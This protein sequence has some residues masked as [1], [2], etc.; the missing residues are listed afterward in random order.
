M[1]V[2][3]IYG[4][5]GLGREVMELAQIINR[6]CK[7]WEDF[8]FIDD[9]DVPDIVNNY[10]VYKYDVAKEK[11]RNS[12]EIVVGIGE[13]VTR[14]KL[15]ERIKSDNIF[16][17]SLIHPDVHVPTTTQIGAGVVIQYGCF[18]SCDVV[19]EDYVYIQPQCNIGHDDV[20]KKG[21]M[22]AS[23]FHS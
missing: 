7:K 8:I 10:K 2:L 15:F 5:S 9:G 16:T 20:L 4:A 23:F 19:I 1:N 21:C 18:I 12:L 13:P 11:Y 6:Q 22:I 3:A 17:P 14:E